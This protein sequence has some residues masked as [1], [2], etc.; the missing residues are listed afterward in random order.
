M[1]IINSKQWLVSSVTLLVPL[2]MLQIRQNIQSE[3]ELTKQGLNLTRKFINENHDENIVVF[4]RVPKTGSLALNLMIEKL[5]ELNNYT[6]FRTLDGMPTNAGNSEYLVERNAFRRQLLIETILNETSG[7]MIYAR[8][9]HFLNFSEFQSKT[10]PIYISFVRHPVDRVISWY[11]YLRN[12]LYQINKEN[13]LL[14]EDIM[15]MSLMKEP[16]EDCVAKGR[17]ACRFVKG[18]PNHDFIN[19]IG[20]FCGQSPECERFESEAALRIAKDNFQRHYA[21]VGVTE[22]FA[23]SVKVLQELLPRYFQGSLQL[24]SED[25]DLL[26]INRNQFRPKVKQRI[27]DQITAN[28]TLEIDFYNFAKQRLFKQYISLSK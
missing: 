25:P 24:L 14:K 2:I 27:R 12:P 4:T 16:I 21:V 8:H 18:M 28:F 1:D 17:P 22:H 19:Q 9:Q 13:G 26:Q 11:Y 6:A 5:R 20:F 10:Q 15:P 23:K 3:L 7:P